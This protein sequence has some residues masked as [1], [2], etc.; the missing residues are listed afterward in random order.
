MSKRAS[1]KNMNVN[2]VVVV[3]HMIMSSGY[4]Q[5]KVKMNA[6]TVSKTGTNR[7]AKEIINTISL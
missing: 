2:K 3:A 6:T 1:S 7:I 4:L 5:R